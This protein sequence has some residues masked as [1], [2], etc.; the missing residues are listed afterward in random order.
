MIGAIVGVLLGATI[1]IVC[2][3]LDRLIDVIEAKDEKVANRE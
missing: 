1:V 2:L 3:R